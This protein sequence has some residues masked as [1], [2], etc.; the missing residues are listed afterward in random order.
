MPIRMAFARRGCGA[1]PEAPALQNILEVSDFEF[2]IVVFDVAL[3]L[4][5]IFQEEFEI[6]HFFDV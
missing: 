2:T 3:V 4:Q 5:Q 6:D 1:V